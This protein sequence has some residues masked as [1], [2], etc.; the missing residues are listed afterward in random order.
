MEKGRKVEEQ[1]K[2]AECEA[3]CKQTLVH[4]H[5]YRKPK[6]MSKLAVEEERNK[7]M[8]SIVC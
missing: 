2:K 8:Q 4:A 6:T 7:F 3:G 5:S 1:V